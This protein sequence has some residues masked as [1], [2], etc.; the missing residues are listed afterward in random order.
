MEIWITSIMAD[1]GYIG[2]FVLIMVENLFPPIPSEII[3]TFGGFM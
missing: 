3:L 1:F 2:I